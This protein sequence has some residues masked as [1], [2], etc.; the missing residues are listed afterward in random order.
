MNV[1]PTEKQVYII[2]ALTEGNSIRATE[3]LTDVHRDTIMSLGVRVGEG[4]ARLHDRLFRELSTQLLQLDEIWSFIGAK[5]AHRKEGHPGYF[6]DCYTWTALDAVNKAIVSYHVGKRSWDDCRVFIGDLRERLTQQ[7]QIT[8]DGYAPYAPTIRAAFGWN[9]DYAQ[10]RK[11]YE[12]DLEGERRD[13]AHRY[14]PG[15]VVR[16]EREIVFGVPEEAQISTSFVERSNLTIRMQ[17]RRWT[18]LTNAFSHKWEN[19]CAA[20]SLFV[21]WY[22]LCRVHETLRCTPAMSLGVSDHI[23]TIGEL[24]DAALA[25]PTAPVTPP[26]PPTTMRSGYRPFQLR[27]IRGGKVSGR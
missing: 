18:R 1:L 25:A 15:R 13:A 23:W 9:V 21:A 5:Q 8:S 4:C 19:H 17:Q 12:E 11:V 10:L 20:M 16:V 6:G 22:N 24:I 3:R 14:S 27:V 2:A 26:K 7:V